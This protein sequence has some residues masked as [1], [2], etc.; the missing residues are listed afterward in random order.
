MRTDAKV[1]ILTESNGQIISVDPSLAHLLR[2]ID[3]QSEKAE[4]PD[5]MEILALLRVGQA[6]DITIDEGEYTVS[7]RQL[8]DI[9]L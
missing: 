8:G 9:T 6:V 3:G 1:Y 7:A 4:Y 5:R 2:E